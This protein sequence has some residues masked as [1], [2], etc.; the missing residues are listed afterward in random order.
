MMMRSSF[1]ASFLELVH[2]RATIILSPT[3]VMSKGTNLR[4][5]HA[6]LNPKIQVTHDHR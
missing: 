2:V 1:H 5:I 3:I 4:I 6:F